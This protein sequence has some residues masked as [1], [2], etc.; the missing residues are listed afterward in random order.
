VFPYVVAVAP[1]EE[2]G[3][4]AFRKKHGIPREAMVFG[5]IGGHGTFD[6]PFVRKVVREIAEKNRD[7][8]FVLANTNPSELEGVE[9]V[10]FVPPTRDARTKRNFFDACDYFLHARTDGETF[11]IAIGEATLCG[12]PTISWTG[13]KD[14][15]HFEILGDKIIPYANEEQLRRILDDP[16]SV[17]V[18]VDAYSKYTPEGV[19][20]LFKDFACHAIARFRRL[21]TRF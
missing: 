14:L 19:T 17:E 6:V 9:N 21:G 18:P 20:P 3:R 5:R 11:G 8:W 13:S 7:K 15:E 10:V 16:P 12:K 4:E 1:P 2:G